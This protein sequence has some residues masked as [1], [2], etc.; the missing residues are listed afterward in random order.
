MKP[1]VW[2]RGPNNS[3][4]QVLSFVPS[5]SYKKRFD[6]FGA[7]QRVVGQEMAGQFDRAMQE[8]VATAR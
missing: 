5:V 7:A 3:L 8:A 1:G 4:K 6:F 2:L